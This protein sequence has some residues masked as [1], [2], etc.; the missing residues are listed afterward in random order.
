MSVQMERQI[1]EWWETTVTDLPDLGAEALRRRRPAAD[2]RIDVPTR[3]RAG[4]VV[5]LAATAAVVVIVGL[6]PLLVFG[7]RNDDPPVGTEVPPTTPAP[8]STVVEQP[9]AAEPIPPGEADSQT[10]VTEAPVAP[11]PPDAVED[12]AAAPD[13]HVVLAMMRSL[14]INEDPESVGADGSDPS[15]GQTAGTTTV[16][17]LD[18]PINPDH[19]GIIV[20]FKAFATVDAASQFVSDQLV[21]SPDGF[22]NV[23]GDY[24]L[25]RVGD[26]A[27]GA[28]GEYRGRAGGDFVEA[29]VRRDRFVAYIRLAVDSNVEERDFA[30]EQAT[31]VAAIADE[32]LQSVL[33]SEVQ[34]LTAQPETLTSYRITVLFAAET[35]D[36]EE[37]VTP[38]GYACTVGGWNEELQGQVAFVD[39]GVWERPDASSDWARSTSG[40][41]L[42]AT[43]QPLCGLWSPILEGKHLAGLVER[44]VG[45]A[46]VDIGRPSTTYRFTHE[47]LVEASVLSSDD[48]VSISFVVTVDDAGPW[49]AGL[50]ILADGNSEDLTQLIDIARIDPPGRLS[51]QEEV[52]H[53][54]VE[55][56]S[57]NDTETLND[58]I[59]ALL[60]TLP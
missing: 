39:G 45:H 2:Q 5:A 41:P 27:V 34:P 55:A 47:D 60:Q 20:S 50:A 10:P 53:F 42:V 46:G 8:A 12:A 1:R 7:S 16:V 49:L 33:S 3:L 25:S 14:P 54:F 38:D 31:A 13:S 51:A 21:Q 17:P 30:I 40:S 29:A 19:G 26:Q 28:F 11:T 59:E 22:D 18:N 43:A 48:E 57:F 6:V 4:W 23:L 52:F 56:G 58:D 32:T 36:I 15:I 35:V 44:S 24:P 37:I 9:Q